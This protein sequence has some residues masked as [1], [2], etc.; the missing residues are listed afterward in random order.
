MKK[1]DLL[2]NSLLL[3]VC[4]VL[5]LA[6]CKKFLDIEPNPNQITTEQVFSSDKTAVSAMSGL[7]GQMLNS[8]MLTSAGTSV[9]AGLYAD[10]IYNTRSNSTD[11]PFYNNSLLANNNTVN[12]NFYR[13]SYKLI[14]Q[15]NSIIAGLEKSTSLTDSIKLQLTG[16][17]KVCRAFLYFYL[18]NLFGDVPLITEMDY[19]KNARLARAPVNEIYW[20]IE[21]DLKE[22]Q[23]LLKPAYPSALRGRPN[24]WAATAL[25]AR[26]YLYQKKWQEAEAQAWTVINQNEYQLNSD[27]NKVFLTGNKETIWELTGDRGNT[28]EGVTFIPFL[29]FITPP[30]NLGPSLL[31]GFEANDKR[32]TDWVKQ[33]TLNGTTYHYPFKY[34][35]ETAEPQKEKSN[36]LRLAEQYLILAEAMTQQDKIGEARNNLNMIRNRAGL[37]NATVTDKASLQIAI[38]QERRIEFFTEWGHRWLDLKRTGRADDILAPMKGS[39]WQTTDK[40]WPIPYTEMQLNTALTQNAGY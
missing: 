11:D 18:C 5:L 25:L 1:M 19:E 36:I 17:A 22:A 35:I 6:S 2:N 37:D 26:V 27:L 31:N 38:E 40:L 4:C 20:Q 14:Y 7:Y 3:L 30:Y 33:V 16:E 24:K 21:N 32:R 9:Y 28:T 10:E 39:N 23:E 34:K 29:F 12:L 13:F 8:L 15:A